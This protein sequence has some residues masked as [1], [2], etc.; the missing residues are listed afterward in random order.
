M[1]IFLYKKSISKLYSISKNNNVE[2]FATI[3]KLFNSANTAM[4]EQFE[5]TGQDG[6]DL[7]APVTA[8]DEI[9]KM[10]TAKREADTTLDY[11]EAMQ[12][13]ISENPDLY[14]RYRSEQ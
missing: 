9:E 8:Y 12:S 5:Q 14:N 4:A 7:G 1:T 6:E 2:D 10:I 11:N 3:E 13:V